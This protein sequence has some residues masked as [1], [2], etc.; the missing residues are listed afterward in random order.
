M[1]NIL[2][3]LKWRGDLSLEQDH[4][5]EIDNLILTR[6][7]YI[8]LEKLM[9]EGEKLKIRTVYERY[10]NSNIKKGSFLLK[11][12]IPFFQAIANSNRFGNLVILKY[13]NKISLKLEE[14]FA[15]VTILLPKDTAFVSFCGTD[16]T[17]VGWKENFNM[18][19]KSH[20]PA[21]RDA[22]AYLNDIG[23][24]YAGN[25]MVGGHSKGGNLA[26]YA[27][28][29]CKPEIQERITTIYSDDGPGFGDDIVES[30]AYKQVVKR[31]V[32]YVPQSSV[33]GRLLL[34][35]EKYYV[36]KST[37]V[38]ILQH[39]PFSWQ[40]E[41]KEFVKVQELTNGSNVTEK[42]IKEWLENVDP[43]RR[44]IFI[45]TLYDILIATNAK[46]VGDLGTNWIRTASTLLKKYKG[47]DEESKKLISQTLEALRKSARNQIL[48]SFSQNKKKEKVKK[49]K[50]GILSK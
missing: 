22:V 30:N 27:A 9:K 50:I 35:E 21:Q 45:D 28:A 18:S 10:E 1:A 48:E 7:S 26:V 33:I 13:V 46:R 17:I 42:T 15:A 25:I 23:E 8:P 19:F 5:N 3:Y 12:D 36:V 24:H 32:S 40:L 37:Q 14:Q 43:E 44:E 29:F 31:V 47:I 2:D 38:G 4:F 6:F 49:K 11:E 20:L 41:G 39:D 34:H 16:D